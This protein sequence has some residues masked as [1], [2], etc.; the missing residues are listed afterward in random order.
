MEFSLTYGELAEAYRSYYKKAPDLPEELADVMIYLLGF[1]WILLGQRLKL[2]P[3][4][5]LELRGKIQFT[6]VSTLLVLLFLIGLGLIQY[7]YLE[8]QRSLKETLDQKVRAISSELGL[9]IGHATRLDSIH[10][11]LGDQLE[12]I[13]D[14]SSFL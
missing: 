7:N 14:T 10:D 3:G 1:G 11:Y 8:F 9:R 6:L 4:N 2:L 5:R 13:S 12:E